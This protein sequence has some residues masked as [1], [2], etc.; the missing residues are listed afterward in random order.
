[1]PAAGELLHSS[2]DETNS[3]GIV[4]LQVFVELGFG[5][6]NVT[7]RIVALFGDLLSPFVEGA[8]KGTLGS[9]VAQTKPSSSFSSS[10]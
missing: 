10:L 8:A 6:L 2:I 1:M 5:R 9:A 4:S 7:E 3:G